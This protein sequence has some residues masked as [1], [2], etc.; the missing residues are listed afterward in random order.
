MKEMTT[1]HNL[2]QDLLVEASKKHRR[3]KEEEFLGYDSV[4]DD[5]TT[6]EYQL[7]YLCSNCSW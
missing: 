2:I 6:H 7:G 5:F 3:I 1:R 4:V